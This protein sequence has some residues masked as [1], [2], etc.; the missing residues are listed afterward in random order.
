MPS[1]LNRIAKSFT[2]AILRSRWV[3]SITLAAS[4]TLMLLAL[5]VPAVMMLAY[6]RSTKR[7]EEHTSEL[8]SLMRISYAVFCLKKKKRKE[9][10]NKYKHTDTTYITTT[11]TE[12][13][14]TITHHDRYSSR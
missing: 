7:S 8:Q 10:T 6:S 3:F 13:T 14:T 1:L 4:A 2:R 11:D 5:W 12:K 9:R